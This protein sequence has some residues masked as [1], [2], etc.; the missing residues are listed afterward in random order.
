MSAVTATAGKA[1]RAG[2]R[3][4]SLDA[5]LLKFAFNVKRRRIF[6]SDLASFVS[7]GIPPQQAL[8]QMSKVAKPRRSMRWLSKLLAQVLR[9]QAN[10]RSTAQSLQR[11]IPPEETALLLA[12]ER[13]ARLKEALLELSGL[14]AKRLSVKKSLWANLSPALMMLIVLV[15]LM[16]YILKTVLNEARGL[17]PES[18]FEQMSLAPLYFSFG[19]AFLKVLPF[20]VVGLVGA[21]I[22]IAVSLPRW[23]PTKARK[24]LDQHIPPYSL[25]ARTQASFFLL[26]VSSMMEAGT[27]FKQA[28]D[29]VQRLAAP[30]SRTHLRR[31][32]A[33][34]SQ[35]QSDGDAM[36]T[37]LL[38]WDVEDRLAIYRMLQ[39]F[40]KIMHVTARDSMEILLAR[41]E[42]IGSAIR[43]SVMVLLGGFIIFTIFSIGEIALQAQSSI[44]QVQRAQ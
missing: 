28:V 40:K 9:E 24:W 12:G 18:M 3:A 41:V 26:T 22:A 38:P 14:L 42:L 35:G 21:S 10:G 32:L 37:G 31:M 39:D 11:W 5:M 7:E 30:W 16:V 33:R 23:K 8:M 4:Q 1:G 20:L 34:L 25:Y 19:E 29:E 6:Y 2:S 43:Y 36:Q 17:V 27:P 15:G 13:G 44:S